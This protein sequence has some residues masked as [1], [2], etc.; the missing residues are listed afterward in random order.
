MAADF[1]RRRSFFLDLPPL[2][3]AMVMVATAGT[4]LAGGD[5][6]STSSLRL[7]ERIQDTIKVLR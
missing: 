5:L 3:L 4:N 1:L 6:T 7:L 2:L